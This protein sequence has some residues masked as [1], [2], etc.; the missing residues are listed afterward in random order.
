MIF[1]ALLTLLAHTQLKAQTQLNPGSMT[2]PYYI[3]TPGHYILMG[4]I[5]IT[6]QSS[7]GIVINSPG[8]TLDLNG[9]TIAGPLNC[10]Q[11][12]CT[13]TYATNGILSQAADDVIQNG[14]ITG[15]YIC[16][17]TYNSS[18]IQNLVISSC[19]LGIAAGNNSIVKGNTVH[20]CTDYGIYSDASLITE[21][22][23][24]G[25]EYGIIA[26]SS[27]TIKNT[28][29]G[30]TYTGLYLY[31]GGLVANNLIYSNGTDEGSDGSKVVYVSNA[32]TKGLC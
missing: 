9:Y 6:S 25:N 30:N 22:N 31:N 17:Q 18:T 1:A 32:C 29:Y 27:N 21:N 5:S 24:F 8:V 23:V 10:S 16:A 13:V 15:F 11:A 7:N 2:F 26:S 3:S 19:Y 28:M 4:N 20:N 12:S 14:R